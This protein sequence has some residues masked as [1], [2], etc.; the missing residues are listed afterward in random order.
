MS[1]IFLENKEEEFLARGSTKA[2]SGDVEEQ[3]VLRLM[4]C[5]G[6]YKGKSSKHKGQR[7]V[8]G[9]V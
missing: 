1:R 3:D 7:C 5:G 9:L 2:K 8:K 6:R 4:V